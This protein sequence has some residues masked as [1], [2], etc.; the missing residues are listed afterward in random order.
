[1]LL[2]LW[3]NVVLETQRHVS[4][5]QFVTDGQNHKEVY[6]LIEM[7]EPHGIPDRRTPVRPFI[8]FFFRSGG[9]RILRGVT[10]Y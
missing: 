6:Y 10:Q 7:D 3:T 1:M 2:S 8:L 4:P 9:Q 5:L